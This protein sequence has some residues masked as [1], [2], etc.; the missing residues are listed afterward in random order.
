MD[1]TRSP[2]TNVPFCLHLDKMSTISYKEFK[3]ACQSVLGLNNV[4]F[5]LCLNLS[6]AIVCTTW[7]KFSN[8]PPK[9]IL[10]FRIV[11]YNLNDLFKIQ[12][13]AKNALPV[14][15]PSFWNQIPE[16]LKKADNLNI[17][18]HS[19]KKPFFNSSIKWIDFY[20]H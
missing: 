16:T 12:A 20:W 17:L 19:F 6:V 10:V 7:M 11:S 18:K 13:L 9:V 8:L 1:Y 2:H 14:I 3:D 15:V 5:Q 4:L